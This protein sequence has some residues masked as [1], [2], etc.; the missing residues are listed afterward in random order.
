MCDLSLP[1]PGIPDPSRGDSETADLVGCWADC[2]V[3]GC[4][5][6]VLARPADGAELEAWRQRIILLMRCFSSMS[7]KRVKVVTAYVSV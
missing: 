5:Q 6:P 1:G 3:D 4:S 2:T 7:T